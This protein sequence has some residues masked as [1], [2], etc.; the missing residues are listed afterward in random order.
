VRD[1]TPIHTAARPG[2]SAPRRAARTGPLS[3]PL[4]ATRYSPRHD[5]RGRR[6]WSR[7]AWEWILA[8]AHGIPSDKP[9]WASRPALTR[10]TLSRPALG[11]WF[12]GY[13]Q[14]R[15]RE[16]HIRPGSFGLIA[17]PDPAFYTDRAPTA[18][19][20]APYESDPERWGSLEWYDRSTA[21]PLTVTTAQAREDPERFINALT[22][23]AIVIDTLGAVLT[24]YSRRAEHKSLAPDGQPTTGRTHGLLRRRPVAS[25][26]VHTLLTGKEGN[27]I[28]ERLTGQTSDVGEYRNDYG[29]RAD[30]WTLIL[31]VLKDIGPSRI[32]VHGIPH[33]TVHDTLNGARPRKHYAAY[34]GVAS[35]HAA[36]RLQRW[37]SEVPAD[38]SSQLTAYLREHDRR[39]NEL[40]LCEHCGRPL[41]ANARS[42]ARYHSDACRKAAHRGGATRV[43]RADTHQDR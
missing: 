20:A 10:F 41:T 7:Q 11:A 12:T 33:S 15:P 8:N 1:C 23:G 13:N 28:T 38:P 19:P 4:S 24:R 32:I 36:A 9:A 14:S 17:H 42:D 18:L 29:T 34:L 2:T 35:A 21:K 43:I 30:T 5:K 3:R 37:G 27:K 39:T 26:P 31:P 40:R 6:V 16:E 22:T 25:S